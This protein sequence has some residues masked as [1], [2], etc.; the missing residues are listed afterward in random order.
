MRRHV[1]GDQQKCH[2]NLEAGIHGNYPSQG[3]H[4][5]VSF[6]FQGAVLARDVLAVQG[7]QEDKEKRTIEELF[8]APKQPGKTPPTFS[9]WEMRQPSPVGE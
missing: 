3:L 6:V 5:F 7:S 9:S 2:R 4:S 1:L 8:L